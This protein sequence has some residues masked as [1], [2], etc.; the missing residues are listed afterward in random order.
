V[1]EWQR[2]CITKQK[3]MQWMSVAAITEE[4][5]QKHVGLKVRSVSS[6]M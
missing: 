4:E 5:A 2:Y 6:H 3:K 1:E